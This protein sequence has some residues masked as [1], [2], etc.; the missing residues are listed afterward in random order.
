MI[1]S[2]MFR[3]PDTQPPRAAQWHLDLVSVCV[4]NRPKRDD[5][6]AAATTTTT[7]RPACQGVLPH[8]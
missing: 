8:T 6:T 2:L 7:T 3:E 5:P 4:L 1:A